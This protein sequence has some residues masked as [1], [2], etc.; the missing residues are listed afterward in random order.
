[1]VREKIEPTTSATTIPRAY[2]IQITVPAA[3][4]NSA[5]PNTTYTGNRAEQDM[6]GVSS[7][8][9]IRSRRLDSVRVA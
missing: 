1:M 8:V 3:V 2:M 6:S 7:A 4:P 9:R 5:R